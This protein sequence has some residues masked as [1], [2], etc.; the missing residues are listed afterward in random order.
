[1]PAGPVGPVAAT[2][3]V[4]TGRAAAATDPVRDPARRAGSGLASLPLP[5]VSAS[6]SDLV[7]AVA[8]HD[9]AAA[10][11]DE[12]AETIVELIALGGGIY[13]E[14]DGHPAGSIVISPLSDTLATFQ[15]VSVHPDFQRHGVASAMVEAALGYAAELGFRRVELFAR[16]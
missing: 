5:L 11:V 12:T 3:R 4:A 16:A 1:M 6:V 2:V 8:T 10:M 9:D 15:R 14:V 7:I 13:A